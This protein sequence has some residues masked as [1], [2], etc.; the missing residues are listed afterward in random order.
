ML[1][2]NCHALTGTWRNRKRRPSK[3]GRPAVVSYGPSPPAHAR[4]PPRPR[5]GR[6]RAQPRPVLP[7]PGPARRCCSRAGRGWRR[8]GSRTRRFPLTI[9]ALQ[10]AL[11]LAAAGG[12]PPV[13]VALSRPLTRGE[14][15]LAEDW[16]DGSWRAEAPDVAVREGGAAPPVGRPVRLTL[17]LPPPP[18]VEGGGGRS[19]SRRPTRRTSRPPSSPSARPSRTSRGGSSSAPTSNSPATGRAGSAPSGRP[20]SRPE[21][22]GWGRSAGSTSRARG[23][24]AGR[25]CGGC[26]Q[27]IAELAPEAEVVVWRGT[28]PPD[29]DD[30]RRPPPRRVR[31]R[32][33]GR[34]REPVRPDA[35][36]TPPGRRPY[37]PLRPRPAQSGAGQGVGRT[38]PAR[39]AGALSGRGGRATPPVDRADRLTHRPPGPQPRLLPRP[40]RRVRARR[41]RARVVELRTEHAGRA[42]MAPR[43]PPRPPVRGP[44]P[45]PALAVRSRLAPRDA[46]GRGPA[47]G[48]PRRRQREP[49]GRAGAPGR[50]RRPRGRSTGSRPT[51]PSG[52]TGSAARPPRPGAALPGDSLRFDGERTDIAAALGRVEADFA[53]RNLRGVVLVSDGRVTDGRNPAYLAEAVPGPDLDG[54][55]RR[56]RLRA[57]RPPRAGGDERRGVRAVAAARPGRR[58]GE[59]VRWRAGAGDGLGRRPRR[60]AVVGRAAGGRGGGGRRPRGDPRRPRA[61]A[62][63]RSRSARSRARRR[64]ATTARRSRSASSTTGAA[65]SSWPAARA[66][67]SP[68]SGPSSRATAR[69]R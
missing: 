35:H 34:A 1:C 16:T 28:D 40:P 67:T 5:P 57:R 4:P 62:G 31:R 65:C 6:R 27:V 68:R 48:R 47:P 15:A 3:A 12:A 60:R 38:A 55:R 22:P 24:R 32:A 17:R 61:S 50:R 49:D 19:R 9:S 10:G 33:A 37:P 29:R 63:T 45:R 53:G 43:G 14:R 64:R 36:A 66:R 11:A 44:V 69:S 58:P 54:R 26:R 56:Q 25:P 2:P 51:P 13:A 20:S 23:P 30:G 18:G 41:R 46:D 39:V 59:R 52:S 21:R 42:G 7:G 8:R